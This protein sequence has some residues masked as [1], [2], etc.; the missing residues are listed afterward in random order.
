M[1]AINILLMILILFIVLMLFNTS[2]RTN[3]VNNKKNDKI[4]NNTENSMEEGSFIDS[5]EN[6]LLSINSN[7]SSYSSQYVPMRQKPNM[8]NIQ[9]HDNYRHVIAALNNLV[10]S[11]KQLFNIPNLPLEYS[12]PG[13]Q[14]VY[15][16][17]S[18]FV[19]RVNHELATDIPPFRL[20]NTGW[21]EVLPEPEI[22]SGWDKAQEALGLQSSLYAKPATNAP[23]RLIAINRVQKYE[24][25]DETKYTVEMVV[26]KENAVDQMVLK[27]SFYL[28][29]RGFRDED[30]FHKGNNVD[31]SVMLES[32]YVLGYLSDD[33]I[34]SNIIHEK[35]EEKFYDFD[36]MEENNM[37]D[38]K[39]IQNIL[40]Q[41]YKLRT[42]E[43]TQR[44]AML[45]EEGQ[46]FHKT[47][48][49]MY[50]Y[51]NIT[52][53]RTIFDDMNSPKVFT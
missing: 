46:E 13:P 21:D 49:N 30:N 39:H 24:T 36:K 47:L 12:E 44:N 38:P 15:K 34:D 33:G 2:R 52:S 22:K 19:S 25:D 48:P 9:F 45:D 27:V 16:M 31:I 26:Q 6:D 20:S 51:S 18:D 28:D 17:V 29:L 50:D 7:Y 53:T 32:I 14:E 8:V 1:D 42:Q 10:P 37:L 11:F 3:K 5:E 23:I 4:T 35:D 40:L 43:M 41:K